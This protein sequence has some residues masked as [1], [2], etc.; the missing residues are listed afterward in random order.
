MRLS[1]SDV[2]H[3]CIVRTHGQTHPF[4]ARDWN[5]IH[6]TMDE[7]AMKHEEFRHMEAI[8]RSVLDSEAVDRLAAYTSM[9]DLIV[10]DVPIPEPPYGVVA[11]RAPGSLRPPR[12]GQVLIEE[13]SVTGHNDRIERPVA[14]AVPLF[15]RFMIEKYGVAPHGDL[16]PTKPQGGR[17]DEHVPP[18]S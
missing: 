2:S 11:V 4:H 1:T 3:A 7:M 8:V 17:A 18:D 12:D 15:W 5:D 10:V 13:M 9:H 6:R 16:N 14:E